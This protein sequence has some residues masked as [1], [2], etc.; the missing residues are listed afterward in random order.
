M[1]AVSDLRYLALLD[2]HHGP[3]SNAS[4]AVLERLILKTERDEGGKAI[5]VL[6]LKEEVCP[7]DD[8]ALLQIKYWLTDPDADLSLALPKSL[9]AMVVEMKRRRIAKAWGAVPDN[10]ERLI[11]FLDRIVEAGKCERVPSAT[12]GFSFYISSHAEAEGFLRRMR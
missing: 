4:D 8:T 11:P 9:L 2:P 7:V 12:E 1:T 6:A 5:V 3:L 10:A